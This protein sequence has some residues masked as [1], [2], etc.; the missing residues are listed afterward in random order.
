[1]GSWSV[2]LARLAIQSMAGVRSSVLKAMVNQVIRKVMSD[3]SISGAHARDGGK[4]DL[5]TL[6]TGKKN[7]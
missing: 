1:V 5:G 7:L 3:A 2:C 4:S 6:S